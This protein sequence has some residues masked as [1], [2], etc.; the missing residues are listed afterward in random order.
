MPSA[1]TT[2]QLSATTGGEN[3]RLIAVVAA[4]GFVAIVGLLAGVKKL[5]HMAVY[6]PIPS[7]EP[8]TPNR[9]R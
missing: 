9:F 2:A 1:F 7:D 3:G 5:V 8:S 4:L 6:T